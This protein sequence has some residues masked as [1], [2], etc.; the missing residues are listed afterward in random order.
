MS[1]STAA[2]ECLGAPRVRAAA[3][4]HCSVDTRTLTDCWAADPRRPTRTCSAPYKDSLS[5]LGA[6]K[7]VAKTTPFDKPAPAHASE[8]GAVAGQAVGGDSVLGLARWG[9]YHS[10]CSSGISEVNDKGEQGTDRLLQ[11]R[12]RLQRD[13]SKKGA[14]GVDRSFEG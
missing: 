5:G 2:P 7:A 8:T 3:I 14:D 11:E 10:E 9:G 6:R 12:V 13:K 1:N 4:L